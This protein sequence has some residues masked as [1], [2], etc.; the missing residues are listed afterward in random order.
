MQMNFFENFAVYITL[1]AKMGKTTL[2]SYWWLK[3][4]MPIGRNA[5]VVYGWNADRLN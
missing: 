5:D 1:W 4:G 3:T 2:V